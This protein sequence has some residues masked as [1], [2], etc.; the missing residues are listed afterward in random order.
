M[1][2]L[3]TSDLNGDSQSLRNVADHAH[4]RISEQ[5]NDQA[6]VVVF[7]FPRECHRAELENYI[8]ILINYINYIIVHM[9]IRICLHKS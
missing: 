5:L 4:K 8:D 1:N 7:F 6:V 3:A 9:L 2:Q